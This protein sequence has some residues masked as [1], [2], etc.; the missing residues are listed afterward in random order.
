MKSRNKW[1]WATILIVSIITTLIP[2]SYMIRPITVNTAKELRDRVTGFYAEPEDSLDVVVL[3]SSAVY[4][5]V[6]NL[7]LWDEY[8][9]TS[10]N[11]ATSSQ[12]VY[13]LEHLVE[14]VNKT[15]SPDLFIVD[16]RRFIVK[17]GRQQKEERIR[18]LVDNMKYSS[19]R[20]AIINELIPKWS[21]RISFYFDIIKYHGEWEN[22]TLENLEYADNERKHETKGWLV[23]DVIKEM[24][25]V[26]A[27]PSEGEISIHPEAEEELR[28]L[29]DKWKNDGVEVLFLS[30]PYI[31]DETNQQKSN[32]IRRIVEEAGFHYLD[33][34]LCQDELNLDYAM[35]FCDSEHVNAAGAEKVSRLLGDYIKMNYSIKGEHSNKVTADWNK[36]LETYNIQK[37]AFWEKYN[38]METK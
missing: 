19:T 17:G 10:Y 3:G 14:E 38:S 23:I 18:Q 11:F 34:N 36:S 7:L 21:D 6:D 4:R 1:I 28:F 12:S 9:I 35:D 2:L 30:T 16:A 8:N 26:G 20:T 37:E 22:L 33:A 13:A 31:I 25:E 27:L 5:F 15:Q 32:Y 24:K 29:L